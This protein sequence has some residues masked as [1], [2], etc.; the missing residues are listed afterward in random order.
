VPR[1]P[2]RLLVPGLF[3]LALAARLPTLGL[4]LE[5]DSAVLASV[6]DQLGHD[7]GWEFAG[8]APFLPIAASVLVASGV[9]A[10]AALRWVDALL[11]ALL[12]PLLLL[13][14]RRLAVPRPQALAAGLL[15]SLHP[16]AL[17][18]AGGV[19]PG[20]SSAVAAV[21]LAALTALLSDRA[22]VRRVG[23]LATLLLVTT[24][25]AALVY[26]PGLLWVY[27]RRE[28]APRF[29]SAV[30]VLGSVALVAAVLLGG[31]PLGG[32]RPEPGTAAAWLALA[33]LGVLLPSVPFGVRDLWRSGSA[34]RAWLLGGAAAVLLAVLG[35]PVSGPAL[36]A[37]VLA[38]G[39]AGA[40]RVYA[41][42][43]PRIVV[44]AFGGAVLVSAWF[45]FGGVQA[46]FSGAA[47]RAAGRLHLLR[48]ALESA[49]EAAGEGGWIV[50]AVAEDRPAEQASLADLLPNHWTWTRR[51]APEN[52]AAADL[53][54]LLVFPA[55]ALEAGRSVAVLAEAGRSGGIETFDGA[56]IYEQE[57]VRQ[58]GPYV[59]LRAR[60]P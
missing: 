14:L 26:V 43:A 24:D 45:V 57:L 3:V 30:L 40:P 33:G 47:P 60:R 18:A 12:A 48:T 35:G 56:G 54:R 11:A 50:L 27:A 10:T 6:A 44:A 52:R 31:S 38:A 25:A 53:R 13:L 9:P 8:H 7:R 55:G 32:S 21:L 23:A 41:H 39:V 29:Q 49:A 17:V 19:Q 51:A 4:P 20:A 1:L 22:G 15:L 36:L 5:G 46:H 37:M 2:L 42:L 16:L 28:A 58:I 34:A 59:V